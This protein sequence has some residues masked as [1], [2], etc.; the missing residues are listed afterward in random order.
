MIDPYPESIPT[1]KP[2]GLNESTK[3]EVTTGKVIMDEGEETFPTQGIQVKSDLEWSSVPT[4]T[5]P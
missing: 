1:F 4:K 5:G 3:S 2:A